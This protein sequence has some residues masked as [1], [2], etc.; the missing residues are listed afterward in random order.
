MTKAGD[1]RP[2]QER[3]T[4]TVTRTPMLFLVRLAL[5]IAV[6]LLSGAVAHWLTLPL[7]FMIGP[8]IAMAVVNMMGVRVAGGP[9]GIPMGLRIFFVPVIGV[10]LGAS[11]TP[12]VARTIPAWWPTL[13][14]LLVY[15]PSIALLTAYLYR[16]FFG[17]DPATAFFS[18]VPG[19]LLEMTIIGEAN[20]GNPAYVALTHFGRLILAVIAIPLALRIV[21]GPVGSAAVSAANFETVSDPADIAILV[22][23]GVAGL[24]G[25]RALRLP[26]AQIAGP[27]LLSALAHGSG[28]VE[29]NPPYLLVQIAQLVI[30]A[31]LGARFGGMS[32]DLM[33][34]GIGAI[35]VGFAVMITASSCIAVAASYL[36]GY[37]IMGTALAFAPGGLTEMSLIALSLHLSVA[38]VSI[39]HIARIMIAVLI[40]PLIYRLLWPSAKKADA[41]ERPD[42]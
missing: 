24:F 18:A 7:P 33:R 9:L 23:C 6:A 36:F 14:A 35:F 21:F 19:G 13:L 20:G 34:K 38:F 40:T 42:P 26:G 2:E 16:R 3:D 41:A 10:M 30:G 4:G 12:E 39:H 22:A 1:G 11:V 37:D 29:G 25:G 27:L 5:S 28:F 32:A 8:L 31:S 15:L 17:F